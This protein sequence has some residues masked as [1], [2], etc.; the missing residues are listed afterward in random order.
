MTTDPAPQRAGGI[1][2]ARVFGWLHRFGH[3]S[4]PQGSAEPTS[5]HEA[6]QRVFHQP[7]GFPAPFL[8]EQHPRRG[9]PKY[10][11]PLRACAE[12][13]AKSGVASAG[14][15]T[16]R[17]RL[18]GGEPQADGI[19]VG[20]RKQLPAA[21]C[22]RSICSPFHSAINHRG[23]HRSPRLTPGC[24]SPSSRTAAEGRAAW[25]EQGL[26]RPTAAG[27]LTQ[28]IERKASAVFFFFL[29]GFGGIFSSCFVFFFF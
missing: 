4:P 21:R 19:S 8:P 13:R 5:P 12:E 28:H 23:A 10:S 11:L 6:R 29:F 14:C 15:A 17:G 27:V 25:G 3:K 20:C 1:S 9:S 2:A 24:Q 7:R 16:R 18:W 26:K 22:N